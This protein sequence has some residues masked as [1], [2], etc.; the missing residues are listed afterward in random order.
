[1]WYKVAPLSDTDMNEVQL[2]IAISRGLRP[3]I[4]ILEDDTIAAAAAEA[5]KDGY[6]PQQ[7]LGDDGQE[8]KEGRANARQL[9][10]ADEVEDNHLET[11]GEG[12]D[13]DGVLLEEEKRTTRA[14][15]VSSLS[16]TAT[17]IT[18]SSALTHV[19]AIAASSSSSSSQPPPPTV[20][21][22]AQQRQGLGNQGS[23]SSST[24]FHPFLS[25]S[26]PMPRVL[27][28]LIERMWH[29]DPRERPE[30]DEVVEELDDLL[31]SS[32]SSAGGGTA[33]GLRG[34]I[35]SQGSGTFFSRSSSLTAG[36]G[37]GGLRESLLHR[38]FVRSSENNITTPQRSSS[39]AMRPNTVSS[40]LHHEV[41]SLKVDDVSSD[42][43]E[44][45]DI[46]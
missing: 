33:A 13:K 20:D 37:G 42:G 3:K 43:N 10:E 1:M 45:Q 11:G 17:S 7:T 21:R 40:P 29:N 44:H 36:G 5:G 15:S 28:Q 16:S 2:V 23:S 14:S 19:P 34:S 41:S 12:V 9:L 35:G 27:A 31:A 38:S 26:P 4:A 22:Q 24:R 39:S 8:R 32:S 6:Q 25:H 46:V 30:I 18:V